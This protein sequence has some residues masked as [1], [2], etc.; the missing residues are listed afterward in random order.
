MLLIDGA[1]RCDS[2]GSL[3]S[4]LGGPRDAPQ[5]R[6]T[7][8]VCPLSSPSKHADVPS[9]D[10]DGAEADVSKTPS[11]AMPEPQHVRKLAREPRTTRR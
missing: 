6:S 5:N 3:A 1:G 7:D 4:V 10:G 11:P 9:N 8:D 2:A